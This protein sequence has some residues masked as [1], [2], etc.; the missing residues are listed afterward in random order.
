MKILLTVLLTVLF[1]LPVTATAEVDVWKFANQATMFWNAPEKMSNGEPITD[2]IE[3]VVYIK[4]VNGIV[5]EVDDSVVEMAYTFTFLIEG[6]FIPGVAAMRKDINGLE[7]SRSFI[8]WG[9]DPEVTENGQTFG[10]RYRYTFNMP[11]NLR[12]S[13]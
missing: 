9:D 10:I 5:T 4:D 11:S 7:I 12:P 3:Y 13:E 1:V 6:D 2:A 8:S